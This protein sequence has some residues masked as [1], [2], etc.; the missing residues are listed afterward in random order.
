M[1]LFIVAK[2]VVNKGRFNEVSDSF[3]KRN[4][5]LAVVRLGRL[6]A[7]SDSFR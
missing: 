6:T 4:L 1:Q 7:V 2:E 5:F 3:Q